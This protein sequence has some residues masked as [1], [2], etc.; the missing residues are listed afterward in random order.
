LKNIGFGPFTRKMSN[1]AIQVGERTS[2][3]LTS[4][5][6]QIRH[7]SDRL[8]QAQRP[9]RILDAIQWPPQI[10]EQFFSEDCRELPRMTRETYASNPLPFER[11]PKLRELRD[12]ERDICR[13]LGHA[14]A[15]SQMMVR[16]C[17]EYRQVVEL[18]TNRGR[19]KFA[20]ISRDLFGSSSWKPGEIG[21]SLNSIGRL[22]KQAVTHLAGPESCCNESHCDAETAA[23]ILSERLRTYF[24]SEVQF[25]MKLTRGLTSDACAG[26]ATISIRG[27]AHFAD[28][29]V[30]LLEVHEGWVHLATTLNGRDQPI[31]AFLGKN[32]PSATVTQ[33]GLAVL[34]EVL[35]GTS[36]P[37]R[38]RR[39]ANRIE[40]ISMAEA[41][42]DFLDV[43]RFYLEEAETPRSSYQQTHR[44]FRGGLPS[45]CGPFTKD[46]GYSKG[47]I[48]ILDSLERAARAGL[49]KQAAL[50]FCGKTCVSELPHLAELVEEGI[51]REP[52]FVPP[53]FAAEAVLKLW[54][55]VARSMTQSISGCT[56]EVDAANQNC[57]D[58]SLVSMRKP[59]MLP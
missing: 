16:R 56:K 34:T 13:Q 14:N 20:S 40:A 10:E 59:S 6:S 49:A 45:G 11:R 50:L 2:S 15:C 21:L 3:S 36:H 32:S 27:D 54:T 17:R 38:L 35:T 5:Q 33:E 53:P 7:L 48:L 43:Y 47:L 22:V 29:E 41:G 26:G 8:V 25:R 39:L 42:A 18:L 4:R 31:C 28:W 58:T 1:S 19:P 23:A 55:T 51:V 12:L 9:L 24:G 46:L 52:E 44:L 37:K 30:R 57:A